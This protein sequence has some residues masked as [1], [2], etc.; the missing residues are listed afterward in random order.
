MRL[1][2]F[3]RHVHHVLVGLDETVADFHGG[4]EGDLGLLRGDHHLG[5]VGAGVAHFEGLG[6]GAGL[7]LRIVDAGNRTTQG[8][9]EAGRLDLRCIEHRARQGVAAR[10]FAQRV[11]RRLPHLG[12]IG[13]DLRKDRSD[14]VGHLQRFQKQGWGCLLEP[15]Q[16]PCRNRFSIQ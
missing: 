10:R 4:A 13:A 2:S 3:Q 9:G 12:L 11:E 7:L 14:G 6:E 1:Y 16:V 8:F 15:V 5:Q